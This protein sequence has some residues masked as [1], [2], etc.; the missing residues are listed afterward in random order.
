[1]IAIHVGQTLRITDQNQTKLLMH[2][3]KYALKEKLIHQHYKKNTQ[4]FS[5]SPAQ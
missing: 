1:M 4:R 3:N 5:P 2:E